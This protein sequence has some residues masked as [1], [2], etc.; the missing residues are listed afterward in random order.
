MDSVQWRIHHTDIDWLFVST[1]LKKKGLYK[2][3]IHESEYTVHAV[4]FW[5]IKKK[6]TIHRSHVF[7]NQSSLI[8]Q[9]VVFGLQAVGTT[10]ERFIANTQKNLRERFLPIFCGTGYLYW[11]TFNMNCK[12]TLSMPETQVKYNLFCCGAEKRCR[13]SYAYFC[14]YFYEQ[15]VWKC[16]SYSIEKPLRL[17][18]FICC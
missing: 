9:D 16:Y 12:L 18:C 15:H 1:I 10:R 13:S 6:K 11:N 4:C 7:V 2:S 5:L 14:A 8:M 17:T 3:F